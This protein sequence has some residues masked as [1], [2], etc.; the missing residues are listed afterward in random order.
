[1]DVN[2]FH[3]IKTCY[4]VDINI[5]LVSIISSTD[6]PV[7]IIITFLIL[8]SGCRQFATGDG[9]RAVLHRHSRASSCSSNQFFLYPTLLAAVLQVFLLPGTA[10]ARAGLP[11]SCQPSHRGDFEGHAA[12]HTRS[13]LSLVR[14]VV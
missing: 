6:T 1:M 3:S 4:R 10:A 5:V 11:R 13:S 12:P 2:L 7:E 8:T 9:G 14:P